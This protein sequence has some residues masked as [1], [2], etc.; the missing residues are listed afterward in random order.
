MS[1]IKKW[2]VIILTLINCQSLKAQVSLDSNFKTLETITVISRNLKISDSNSIQLLTRLNK[3]DLASSLFRTTPEA[4]MGSSGVF[5]QKTNHG[6]GSAFI[7]GLTGNQTLMVIDGI[8]LNNA[9]HRYGPNQYLNT[10]DIFSIDKIEIAKGTG[11]VAYGSDAMGGAILLESKENNFS[12]TSKWS[13]STLVK[14]IT[15]EMEK[16]NRSEIGFSNKNIAMN[17]GLTFRNFG[18]VVGGNTI[19]SQ[20]PSGYKETDY[21]LK[22]KIKTNDKSVLTIASQRLKQENIPIYHKILLENYTINQIDQQ[23]HGLHYLK[24]TV[25]NNNKWIDKIIA[26]ASLQQSIEQRSNQ[27]NNSSTLRKEADTIIGKA[28]SLDIIS[29]PTAFWKINTGF[30]YYKDKIYSN[31]S[32][33][34]L[35][36]NSITPKRG[37]YPNGANYK[38]SSI[39]S[40]HQFLL[41]K[42]KIEAG[43]RYNFIEINIK[44]NILGDVNVKPSAIVYNTGILYSLNKNHQ[45]YSSIASGYRAPN[46][47]DMGT[48][49][50]VD[51]RYE[52]PAYNL[53]PE[54]SL[55]TEI[56]YKYIN[57][58]IQFNFS[59][60]QMN[61]RDIIARV[62]LDGQVINGYTVYNKENIESSYIK[63]TEVNL[64]YRIGTN[65]KLSSNVNY[66]YGQNLTKNEPMRRIPPM[67]GQNKIDWNSNKL[68]L[69]L[70]HQYAGKQDRLAQGDK[71]DNRIGKLGTPQWNVFHIE[72]VYNKGPLTCNIA[73]INILNEK[74]KTHGSGI[75]GMG[76]AISTSLQWRF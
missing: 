59:A 4:L 39:F 34:N 11:S 76:R 57:N 69:S 55:N 32:D 36:F 35:L 6:G 49:G 23:L 7:R 12:N 43:L 72:G 8:R 74:Y 42:I 56:G 15:S 27:K 45:I 40:L 46:I 62:K 50:I 22:L 58:N 18:D 28:F 70:T 75:Y 67:F 20:S 2:L 9:T 44:D 24:Y 3:K 51:F 31:T 1:Q 52:V 26:T 60:Y 47:D 64:Q 13:A 66:T 19:G 17:G 25:E 33:I 63:G 53:E 65:I 37:L 61:L 38:S 54:K 5:I 30:D 14:Y 71:D 21:D 16:T 48:L 29:K 41:K 68:Q 73:L 10:I